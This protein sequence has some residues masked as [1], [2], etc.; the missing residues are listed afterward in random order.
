MQPSRYNFDTIFTYIPQGDYIVPKF[1]VLI[2]GVRFNTGTAI[3]RSS[4]LGGLN[5]FNYIGRPIAGTWDVATSTLNIL[6]FY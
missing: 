2:N 3:Y 4:Y 5:L 1:N 6:G